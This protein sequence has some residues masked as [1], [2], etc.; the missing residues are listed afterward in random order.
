MLV[1]D[2]SESTDSAVLVLRSIKNVVLGVHDVPVLVE[3]EFQRAELVSLSTLE[4]EESVLH[5]VFLDVELFDEGG[6]K[7][8]EVTLRNKSERGTSVKN[9]ENSSSLRVLVLSPRVRIIL[10]LRS[11]G[12]ALAHGGPVEILVK[13]KPVNFVVSVVFDVVKDV[14]VKINK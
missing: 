5:L 1:S 6:G 10:P 4:G 7:G 11:K 9:G 3:H 8:A 12:H 13:L 14:T 2:D